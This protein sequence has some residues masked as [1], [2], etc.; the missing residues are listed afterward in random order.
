MGM[1]LGRLSERNVV[2][3]GMGIVFLWNVL[4]HPQMEFTYYRSNKRFPNQRFARVVFHVVGIVL[5]FGGLWGLW[6]NW[7]A[8]R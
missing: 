8:G 3:L 6:I 5:I 2:M 7:H 1:V 4:S